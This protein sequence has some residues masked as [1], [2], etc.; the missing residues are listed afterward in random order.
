MMNVMT[1]R[2]APIAV[3]AALIV[4]IPAAVSHVLPIVSDDDRREVQYN[5]CLGLGGDE[6]GGREN[7]DKSSAFQHGA[8]SKARD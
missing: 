8:S 2:L 4:S 7:N 3:A 6:Q 5:H 1:R